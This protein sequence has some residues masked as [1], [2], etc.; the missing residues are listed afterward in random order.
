[1]P[2]RVIREGLLDSQRYWAVSIEARQLFIHL[3]LLADDFG[4]VSLAPVFLRR[5]CFD[6]P[7]PDSKIGKQ[8]GELQ[9]EDLIRVYEI[10]EGSMP[11]R[12]AFI[13]RFGQRL[14]MMRCKHPMP[15]ESLFSDDQDAKQKFNEN[16]HLFEKLSASR[17]Q[18]AD[19]LRP[20][21][22]LEGKRRENEVESKTGQAKPQTEK[23]TAARQEKPGM[24]LT[25]WATEQ[26]LHRGATESEIDFKKR[27]TDAYVK[28][29]GVAT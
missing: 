4:L 21:V 29:L 3:M 13:P 17:R 20:E 27:A 6:N 16:R 26:G 9:D 19:N 24:D 10:G 5:R 14:R 22:D 1:M 25:R 7:P 12:Y 8:V 18:L 15:P 23:R 28:S 2:S 11:A